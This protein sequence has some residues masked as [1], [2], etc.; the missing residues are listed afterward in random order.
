MARTGLRHELEERIR[1]DWRRTQEVKMADDIID[2]G[3]RI[4]SLGAEYGVEAL[5]RT[6]RE[7]AD[8]AREFDVES[9][10]RGFDELRRLAR[11]LDVDLDEESA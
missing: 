10:D 7:L 1:P 9:M 11:T 6:G 3:E 5:A 2:F 8:A 4:E